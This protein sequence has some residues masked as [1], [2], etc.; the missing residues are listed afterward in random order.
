[1]SQ[2][3]PE[4]LEY[5]N[6]VE[7]S[8]EELN[9]IFEQAADLD[10]QQRNIPDVALFLIAEKNKGDVRKSQAVMS[11]FYALGQIVKDER[12]PGWTVPVPKEG[13]TLTRHELIHAAAVFPLSDIDGDV[14]FEPEGFLAKA[15]ELAKSEG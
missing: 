15:L 9:G 7:V 11:R 10:E 1:M 13:Y 3:L 5:L 12:A 14:G 2:I 4:R 6:S 8:F